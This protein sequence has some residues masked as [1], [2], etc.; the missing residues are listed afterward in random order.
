MKNL[1]EILIR[2]ADP[3]HDLDR[4]GNLNRP[5]FLEYRNILD[6]S[7]KFENYYFNFAKNIPIP[8]IRFAAIGASLGALGFYIA[9][10]DPKNGALLY[11]K[12]VIGVDLSQY[13]IR[14]MVIPQIKAWINDIRYA[15]RNNNK[16]L[17]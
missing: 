4:L 1:L 8:F 7:D 16:S 15:F 10:E 12:L 11:G 6:K 3:R 14:G 17:K 13:L 2:D 9:G 5:D